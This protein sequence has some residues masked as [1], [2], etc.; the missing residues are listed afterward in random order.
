M[1]SIDALKQRLEALKKQVPQPEVTFR[2]CWANE[3]P[4]EWKEGTI[5][6]THW[7]TSLL[8]DEDLEAC[9]T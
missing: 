8:E 6:V 3:V 1:S 7:G 4:E 9:E 5:I 2:T